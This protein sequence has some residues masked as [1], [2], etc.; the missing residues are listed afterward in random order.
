MSSD[1]EVEIL[2]MIVSFTDI[3]M[4]IT[5]YNIIFITGHAWIQGLLLTA[6]L[7]L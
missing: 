2:Y 7:L 3:Y 1:N 5:E 4:N 6:L